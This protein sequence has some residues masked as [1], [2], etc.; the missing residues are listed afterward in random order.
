MSKIVAGHILQITLI[1]MKVKTSYH[2]STIQL[3]A[4][5]II[6]KSTVGFKAYSIIVDF[7]ISYIAASCAVLLAYMDVVSVIKEYERTQLSLSKRRI[8]CL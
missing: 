5:Y 7:N 3:A 8:Q 1:I 4:Q 6:L 2:N